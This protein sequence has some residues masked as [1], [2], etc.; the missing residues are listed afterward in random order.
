MDSNWDAVWDVMTVV[1][2]NGW[3]AEFKIPWAALR[4]AKMEKGEEEVWGAN[5]W[6]KIRRIREFSVWEPMDATSQVEGMRET[7]ELHGFSEIT[8]PPRITFFPYASVYAESTED[9]GLGTRF[10]GGLDFKAGI[11]DAFTLDMTLIPDFGQVVADNLIL[12]LSA[13][14]IQF[15]DNRPFFTEGTE[16]FNKSG[17][18][19]SRRVGEN[20]QLINASKFSGRTKGGLGIGALQAFAIDAQDSTENSPITSYSVAVL[21]QSLPNNGY[22]HGISTFV[23]KDGESALVQG[24]DFELRNKENSYSLSGQASYSA[25]GHTWEI[26]TSKLSGN[27]TWEA[28]HLEESKFYDPNDLGYLQAPN[29]VVNSLELVY[30]IVEPFGRFVNLFSGVVVEHSQLYS[31]RTFSNFIVSAD[32]GALTKGFQFAR[33]GFY[34]SPVRGVDFFEPRLDGYSFNLPAWGNADLIISTD[35]RKKIAF[36]VRL[37]RSIAF[38]EG[39]DWNGYDFRIEPRFRI[40]D[41]LSFRYVYSY[42]GQ[43]SELGYAD[44][45]SFGKIPKTV[46]LFGAR[47]NKSETHVLSAS[48]ILSNRSSFDIRIRHY[49]STVD[50]LKFYELGLDSELW[51]T[52]LVELD[53]DNTSEYDVNYNAWSVDLGFRWQFSPGS[54][55]SIV[56]KNTLQSRGELLPSGY[57]ENWGQMLEETFVNS[58]SIKALYYLDYSTIRR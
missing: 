39:V 51:E 30:Q 2:E 37:A 23:T 34:G 40:N 36:D 55:L 21:D 52:T 27:F 54:E 19:Y 5:F 29:E 11:G 43:L 12:N 14:E 22:V 35:Y 17:L 31:P 32:C 15:Q 13:F 20:L 3:T 7:G 25:E 26:G 58:L 42:Q 38:T 41:K 46:S 24:V 9:G 47:N 33:L 49:W 57:F 16:L 45:I 44:T 53:S 28:A 10:S 48:Y 18:F 6:R 50:Y 4:F 56:W 8:P 1:D